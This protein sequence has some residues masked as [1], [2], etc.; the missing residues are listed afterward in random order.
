MHDI[1]AWVDAL[2]ASLAIKVLITLWTPALAFFGLVLVIHL[3]HA[4]HDKRS[5][6]RRL[7]AIRNP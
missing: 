2:D 3:V 7:D 5:I 1:L 4:W 6:R